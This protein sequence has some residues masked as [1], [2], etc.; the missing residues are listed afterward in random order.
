MTSLILIDKISPYGH[1][2]IAIQILLEILNSETRSE[3]LI[4]CIELA[5]KLAEM[6]KLHLQNDLNEIEELE[7]DLEID[8]Q[9]AFQKLSQAKN[10]MNLKRTTLVHVWRELSQLYVVNIENDNQQM[11]PIE[12]NNH[13]LNLHKCPFYCN[14]QYLCKQTL[15]EFCFI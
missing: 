11:N 3:K 5:N 10:D 4:G 12:V 14:Q 9:S 6:D 13:I 15:K 1:C 8:P 2:P 7:R